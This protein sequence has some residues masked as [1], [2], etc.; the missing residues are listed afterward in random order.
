M[1]LAAST[2]ALIAAGIAASGSTA[3]AVAQGKLNKKNRKWQE[4]MYE[5]RKNDQLE[6]WQLQ[7]AYNSPEAQ[8]QRY[9]DAGLNPHLIYGQT[10][11]AGAI[12]P[13]SIGNPSTES[14]RYGDA[15]IQATN[16]AMQYY[17]IKQAEIGMAKDAQSIENMK[18]TD[19]LNS[20][21]VLGE[22]I[23]NDSS[24]LKLGFFRDTYKTSVELLNQRLLNMGLSADQIQAETAGTLADTKRKDDY[25]DWQKNVKQTELDYKERMVIVAEKNQIIN[26]KNYELANLRTQA[27]LLKT[28]AQVTKDAAATA[29]LNKQYESIDQKIQDMKINRAYKGVTFGQEWY[30]WQHGLNK[31]STYLDRKLYEWSNGA[32]ALKQELIRALDKAG[33]IL[34]FV[35]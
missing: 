6:N 25:F 1:P 11:E 2:A 27:L 17:S 19:A 8:M 28:A 24:L 7:N 4:M 35:K 33:V 9:K 18:T 26:S 13:A 12:A 14:P 30:D 3:N 23:K 5:R 16:Q 15:A 10:N 31:N 32:G 21:K 22:M 20:V 29:V 34:R